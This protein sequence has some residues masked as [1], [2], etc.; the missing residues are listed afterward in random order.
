MQPSKCDEISCLLPVIIE[1]LRHPE[2]GMRRSSSAQFNSVQL[3]FAFKNAKKVSSNDSKTRVARDD[4]VNCNRS[5]EYDSIA[6]NFI[7]TDGKKFN[8][9]WRCRCV[10]FVSQLFA[11]I[12]SNKR[13][14]LQTQY[15]CSRA[16]DQHNCHTE[17]LE[18]RH[19]QKMHIFFLLNLLSNDFGRCFRT[20]LLYLVLWIPVPRCISFIERFIRESCVRSSH[21]LL[22]TRRAWS[23]NI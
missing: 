22:H 13:N 3:S 2:V 14:C 20:A 17:T 11:Q 9:R 6:T 15:E 23:V 5:N 18:Q 4:S 12:Q 10:C 21:E 16:V 1:N 8:F 19:S 7:S